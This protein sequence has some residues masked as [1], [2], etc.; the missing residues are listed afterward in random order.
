MPQTHPLQH[1][2]KQID[3]KERFFYH[4]QYFSQQCARSQICVGVY[5][6]FLANDEYSNINSFP[7]SML[8]SSIE[9]PAVLPISI[10]LVA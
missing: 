10:L 7:I 4:M 9:G 5:C 1:A 6:F 3:V 2:K 8:F